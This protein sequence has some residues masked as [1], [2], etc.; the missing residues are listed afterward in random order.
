MLWPRAMILFAHDV[1]PGSTVAAD[2]CV[3]GAG[4]VGIALALTL[5]AA[6]REVL[7]LEAGGA[8]RSDESQDFYRGSVADAALHAGLDEY[9][10]RCLGGTSTMWGGRCMPLDPIDFEARDWIAD[11]GWPIAATAL[12]DHYR[13][14]ARWCEV[15]EPTFDA[16]ADDAPAG[17]PMI[18]GFAGTAFNDWSLERLSC[19]TDFGRRYHHRLETTP[20]L[21]VMLEAAVTEIVTDADGRRITGLAVR[22]GD[23][24]AFTVRPAATVVASGGMETAR[25]LL[26]SRSVVAQGVGN[27]HDVV[28]RYYMAH[29][30]GTIGVLTPAGGPRAVWHGYDIADDGTYVRRRLALDAVAQRTH[31]LGN[32]VARL[33]HPTIGDP[34]H[35]TA[36]LS[37]LYLGRFLIPRAYRPRLAGIENAGIGTVLHHVANVARDPLD[38]ARFAMRMGLGRRLA[39]RK[40]PSVIVT[41]RTG[42][43]MLDFHAEQEPNRDSRLTLSDARDRWGMPRLHVDWRYTPGDVHTVRGALALLRDDLERGGAGTLR[44]DEDSVEREMIRYGAYPGHHIGTTRMGDDPRTSV[45]DRDCRVHDMENLWLAGSAVFPT[46]GQA[47]PTLTAVALALRLADHLARPVGAIAAS[48]RAA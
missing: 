43:Y 44:Y 5:A 46:S 8:G 41:P 17:P 47:N 30:A 37:A 26:A 21:R 20:G 31:R 25:L 2:V 15:G 34:A 33:H 48:A 6:G 45:V 36:S 29:L 35:G 40:F 14:A 9:R 19:P 4:P 27:R 42:R 11:S 18:A 38:V 24:R 3:V 28:G 22:G 32:F 23:G 12:D 7:L 39:E 1:E 16:R 13:A 10:A